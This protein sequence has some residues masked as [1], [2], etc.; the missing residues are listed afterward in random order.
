[1]KH[2]I[3]ISKHRL[4]IVAVATLVSFFGFRAGSAALDSYQ[5]DKFWLIS[6]YVYLFLV[7]WQ[8]FVF[9][10]H[11]KTTYTWS[12]WEKSFFRA[13]KQRFS[14]MFEK[15]HFGHY[16]N[17]LIL[18]AIIYWSTVVMLFLNP[19]EDLLKSV[20]ASA[21]AIALAISFWYLKTVFYSHVSAHRGTKQIIFITKLFASY[22]S[23]T[24][25]F[26]L[27]SYFGLGGFVFG[28]IIFALTYLL[29]HQA[30]FQH[31]YLGHNEIGLIL[32]SGLV[33]AEFGAIIYSIWNVN[34][35]TGALAVAAVYNTTWGI[36]QHKFI[37][38]NLNR[39]IVYEYLAVLF[40]VLVVVFSTTDF[41]EKLPPPDDNRHENNQ[42]QVK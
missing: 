8:S 23:F 3:D 24:A 16:Q 18:P 33:T 26:G 2:L 5:L 17:Y 20:F 11:L 38:K 28:L 12:G 9:D 14:Y 35:Y 4:I 1:M 15:N 27:A 41:S 39:Q 21:G 36:M 42:H 7:F 40:V 25:A 34:Y 29:I 30:F 37:D 22:A 10:L 19:F 32:L 6:L 13:L 31:H